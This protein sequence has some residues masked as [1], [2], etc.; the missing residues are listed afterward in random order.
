MNHP[1]LRSSITPAHLSLEL[2]ILDSLI[3]SGLVSNAFKHA[4]PQN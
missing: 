4:F 3:V 2:V 1:R